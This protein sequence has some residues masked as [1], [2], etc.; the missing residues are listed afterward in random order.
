MNLPAVVAHTAALDVLAASDADAM[1]SSEIY[2]MVG[3]I[4]SAQFMETVAGRVMAETYQKVKVL[5]GEKGKLL[6]VNKAGK[7]AYVSGMEAFCEA[8]MPVSARRCRQIIAAIDTIGVELYEQAERIGFRARDY[9][10]LRALPDDQQEVVKRAIEAGDLGSAVDIV[11][12]LAARCSA[13]QQKLA[14]AEKTAVAKDGVIKKKN[15]KIDALTEAEERRLS[16]NP[17]EREQAQLEDLRTTGLAAEMAVRKLAAAAGRTVEAPATEAAATAARQAVEFVA[18]V[19]A[20]LISDA[21]IEVDFAEM[22]TP[23]WLAGT[24]PPANRR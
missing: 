19:L 8:V 9:Q 11:H 23:H 22:V 13:V 7:P 24:T 20:G 17:D 12:E 15:E 5:I 14:E 3:R 10:A 4:E 16:G 21:G 18:Q 2:R 6:V 1:R